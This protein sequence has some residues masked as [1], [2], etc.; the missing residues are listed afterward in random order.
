[1]LGAILV[2]FMS[3]GLVLNRINNSWIDGWKGVLIL[4]VVVAAAVQIKG[5]K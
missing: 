5:R 3:T 1:M 4:L 2:T